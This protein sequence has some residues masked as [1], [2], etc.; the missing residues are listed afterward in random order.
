[1]WMKL[2]LAGLAGQDLSRFS[3][4]QIKEMYASESS[5]EASNHSLLAASGIGAP[6]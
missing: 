3:D 6:T 1:M 5:V 4:I 2:K